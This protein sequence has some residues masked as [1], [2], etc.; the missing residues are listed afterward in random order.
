MTLFSSTLSIEGLKAVWDVFIFEGWSA[1][2]K[3]ITYLLV[4]LK[5]MI[6]SSELEGISIYLKDNSQRLDL[7]IPNMM[8]GSQNLPITDEWLHQTAESFYIKLA[9]GQLSESPNGLNEEEVDAV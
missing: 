9:K 1:L 4:D 3:V 2:M 8:S 5:D 7:N 6:L